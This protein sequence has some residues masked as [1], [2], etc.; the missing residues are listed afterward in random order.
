MRQFRVNLDPEQ[1][2][3]N[4]RIYSH[5]LVVIDERQGPIARTGSTVGVKTEIDR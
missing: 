2:A 4:G 3:K 1:A 5:D